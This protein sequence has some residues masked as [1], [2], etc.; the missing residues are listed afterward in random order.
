VD[1]LDSGADTPKTKLLLPIRSSILGPPLLG[2]WR[3]GLAPG[4]DTPKTKQNKAY[5]YYV[6]F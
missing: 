5:Q 2:R 4:T 3:D 1:G 6:L